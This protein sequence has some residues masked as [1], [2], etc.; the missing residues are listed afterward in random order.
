MKLTRKM[1]MMAAL[2]IGMLLVPMADAGV[3]MAASEGIHVDQVVYLEDYSKVA[4]V[5]LQGDSKDFSLVDT[6]TGKTVYQG[7]LTDK[8]YDEMSGEYI[9]REDF[10]DFKVPGT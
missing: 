1:P 5:S 2:G 4:M 9:A 8:A 7:K 10:S 6:A 3:A